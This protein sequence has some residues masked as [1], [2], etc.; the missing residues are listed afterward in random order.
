MSDEGTIFESA[1]LRVRRFIPVDAKTLALLFAGPDVMRS[2]GDG[3][4]R[5]H[6][7][8]NAVDQVQWFITPYHELGYDLWAVVDRVTGAMIGKAGI[9]RHEIDGVEEFETAYMLARAA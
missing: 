4:P 1:R 6:A 5:P 9:H 2:I 8:D 3:K 7:R